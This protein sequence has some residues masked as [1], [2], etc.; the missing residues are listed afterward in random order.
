MNCD[1]CGQNSSCMHEQLKVRVRQTTATG[2][3]RGESYQPW[4][5]AVLRSS[6]CLCYLVT[7]LAIFSISPS[8][9]HNR[10]AGRCQPVPMQKAKSWWV[11]GEEKG[12]PLAC[13]STVLAEQ[14]HRPFHLPHNHTLMG[15][16]QPKLVLDHCTTTLFRHYYGHHES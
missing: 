15:L 11:A 12:E 9:F 16:D 7:R 6:R 10:D 2:R 3:D 5:L 4:Q 13:I 14:R 1:I 8:P